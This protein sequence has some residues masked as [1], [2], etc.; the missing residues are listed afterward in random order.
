MAG[1]LDRLTSDKVRE[2][3]GAPR[4][5]GYASWCAL[6]G[7]LGPGGPTSR[8]AQGVYMR[9]NILLR[10]QEVNS[11]RLLRS[12]HVEDRPCQ[13]GRRGIILLG[14]GYHCF[15]NESCGD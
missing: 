7:Y 15:E 1:R 10:A 3:V 12:T 13:K 6:P 14:K 9:M 5:G 8:E 2:S 4:P 11:L